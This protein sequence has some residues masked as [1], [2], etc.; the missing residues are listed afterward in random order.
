MREVTVTYLSGKEYPL[1]AQKLSDSRN[2]LQ[3]L[4][5]TLAHSN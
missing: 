5:S 2:K 1:L 3:P 4:I